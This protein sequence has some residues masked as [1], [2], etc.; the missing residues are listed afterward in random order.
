[1]LQTGKSQNRLLDFN[2]QAEQLLEII[3]NRLA[4]GNRDAAK[5]YLAY[6][7]QSLYT[8]GVANGRR[9]EKEG[10]YPF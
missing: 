1:M 8:Q 3:E 7:F 4:L 9:Y 5:E 6:K 10:E 2:E